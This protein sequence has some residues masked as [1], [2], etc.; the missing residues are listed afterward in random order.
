MKKSLLLLIFSVLVWVNGFSQLTVTTNSVANSLA[1][2]ITGNGVTVSN[3]SINCNGAASGT[4]NYSGSN[5]GLTSG[6][7]LSTGQAADAVYPCDHR[8]A[9]AVDPDP[10]LGRAP[11]GAVSAIA[12]QSA[13]HA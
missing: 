6:I 1:Q 5:L 4:F 13:A 11:P 12:A 8:T 10:I 3:A 2:T 9:T 7:I